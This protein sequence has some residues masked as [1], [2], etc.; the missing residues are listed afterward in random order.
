MVRDVPL[1]IAG[2]YAL[3]HLAHSSR[4]SLLRHLPCIKQI[5]YSREALAAKKERERHC[6]EKI[7][8]A[9]PFDLTTKLLHVNPEFHTVWNYR[10]NILLNGLFSYRNTRRR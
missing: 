8:I 5:K 4:S 1:P 7:W 3:P 9:E 6:G 10:R 2:V